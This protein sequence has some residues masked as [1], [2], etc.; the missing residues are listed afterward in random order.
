MSVLT[1]RGGVPRIRREAI[2]DG[3]YTVGL[4]DTVTEG[5]VYGF[6]T[7]YLQVRAETGPVRLFFTEESFTAND[8]YIEIP[9][10][11]TWGGPAETC[12]IWLRGPG[13]VSIV[14]YQ[15]RA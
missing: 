9:A 1:L 8:N 11:E 13:D 12:K 14:A 10:G 5:G 15:R 2:V 7:N 4:D 6:N 3:P